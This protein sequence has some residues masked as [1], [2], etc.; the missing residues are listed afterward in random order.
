MDLSILIVRLHLDISDI[1]IS[2]SPYIQQQEKQ[3][4]HP[5]T[6]DADVAMRERNLSA[7]PTHKADAFRRETDPRR[8]R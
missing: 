3:P 2:P 4:I 6:R 5:M 1:S 8:G 7:R